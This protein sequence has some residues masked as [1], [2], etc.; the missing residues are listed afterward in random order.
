MTCSSNS[1]SYFKSSAAVA[2]CDSDCLGVEG[3]GDFECP[4]GS[5]FF[6]TCKANSEFVSDETANRR[7]GQKFQGKCEYFDISKISFLLISTQ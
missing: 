5:G 1:G 6:K 3:S 4:T 2:A 7:V